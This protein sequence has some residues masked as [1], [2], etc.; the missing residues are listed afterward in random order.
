MASPITRRHLLRQAAALAATSLVRGSMAQSRQPTL[1]VSHDSTYTVPLDFT[2]LSYEKAQLANP[3]FFSHRNHALVALFRALSPQGVLRL[4]GGS[5]EF[6]TYV[7]Q[8]PD[9][10]VPFEVFGPDTSKTTKH[11]T[12]TTDA[13]L[14]ALRGFLDATGWSCL[15]GLN[16]GQGTAENAADEAEAVTRLLGPRL[17]ALQIGNE[18]DSFRKRYRPA[19]Y[20]PADFLAEWE[21]MHRVIRAR[22]PAARFA[23]PD[24]SNKLDYFLAFAAAAPQWHD[25]TLLTSHAYAMGPAGSPNSTLA[26]L[27]L[28]NPKL[29]TL[30]DDKLTQVLAASAN[31]HLPYR[32]CEA[33]S[34]W[35][36]GKPGVS[37]TLASSLWCADY[38]LHLA[39]RGVSGIN[40][41]GG[42]NGYY[43]PIAGSPSLGFTRRP[44]YFGIQ[45]AQQFAG[46]QCIPCSL[47][48]TPP[49]LRAYVFRTTHGLQAAVINLSDEDASIRL[50]ADVRVSRHARSLRGGALDSTVPP[51]WTS[52][53]ASTDT[54]LP[55]PARSASVYQLHRKPDRHARRS[56][57]P[58]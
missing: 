33:N 55:V 45:F 40:L 28:P 3:A 14:T 36:G 42:G 21:H 17:I 43:T 15:Y 26:N 16:L 12:L 11:G 37:D 30:S 25:V 20:T 19:T 53:R 8:A 32:L 23:G 31:A 50:A 57:E 49:L 18:P 46:S 54:L 51:S 34:C 38:M 52:L 47:D 2:G 35:D 5:S 39:T 1:T 4:G 56:I 13:A 29:Q 6:A 44:E 48:T 27:L 10:S 9:A 41:H 7:A 58:L 24:I 22:V